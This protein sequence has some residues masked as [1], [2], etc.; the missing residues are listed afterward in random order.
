M[1]TLRTIDKVRNIFYHVLYYINYIIFYIEIYNNY[2]K[3]NNVIT[4]V[5][6][7]RETK[8]QYG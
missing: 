8:N 6:Y 1:E 4:E 3:P 5:I 7:N 2:V